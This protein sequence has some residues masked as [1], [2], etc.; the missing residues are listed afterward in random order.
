MD[1]PP[2]AEG[3]GGG[4]MGFAHIGE[5]LQA[6]FDAQDASDKL[7]ADALAGAASVSEGCRVD[8]LIGSS[9]PTF[10]AT[11]AS[12]LMVLFIQSIDNFT[13][14]Y[15]K[16]QKVA[17]KLHKAFLEELR[18]RG[19]LKHYDRAMAIRA[20][21]KAMKA[22]AAAM[23]AKA[24]AAKAKVDETQAQLER[25]EAQLTQ[26]EEFGK[27]GDGNIIEN[28]ADRAKE[29]VQERISEAREEIEEAMD[30]TEADIAAMKE[31]L[32][33]KALKKLKTAKATATTFKVV[34]LTISICIGN[35][36]SLHRAVVFCIHLELMNPLSGRC[37][38]IGELVLNAIILENS[39]IIIMSD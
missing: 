18:K 1:Q 23:K 26:V 7:M 38:G 34:N 36:H 6:S 13:K 31:K 28:A 17:I 39:D 9:L 12:I 20:K 19:L 2:G 11:W 37:H 35:I 29:E 8:K 25:A 33:K 22:K 10:L 30:V 3:G 21:Y 24:E 16:L 5:L 27:E 15:F 4:M 14:A 32:K